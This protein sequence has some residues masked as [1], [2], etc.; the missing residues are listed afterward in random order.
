MIEAAELQRLDQLIHQL[1][2]NGSGS[3]SDQNIARE[4]EQILAD[5]FSDGGSSSSGMPS[6]REPTR[7]NAKYASRRLCVYSTSRH[8]LTAK[9][10]FAD[11]APAG[12]MARHASLTRQPPCPR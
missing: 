4:I 6:M 5:L 3:E 11:L 7:W 2:A 12:R 10:R 8:L 9:D 1:G